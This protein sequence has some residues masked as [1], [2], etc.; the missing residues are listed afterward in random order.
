VSAS[1]GNVTD[2]LGLV[3]DTRYTASNVCLATP[4][5]DWCNMSLVTDS[6]GTTSLFTSLDG[7]V[8]YV[9]S[10]R[11]QF[12]NPIPGA[13]L[14]YGEYQGRSLFVVQGPASGDPYVPK[15]IWA[16]PDT[17]ARY[18]SGTPA[19]PAPALVDPFSVVLVG[20]TL[21][22]IYSTLVDFFEGFT[23]KEYLHSEFQRLVLDRHRSQCIPL[24]DFSAMVQALAYARDNDRA[25]FVGFLLSALPGSGSTAAR[26]GGELLEIIGGIAFSELTTRSPAAVNAAVLAEAQEAYAPYG[27]SVTSSTKIRIAPTPREHYPSELAWQESTLAN[28]V[29]NDPL[30]SGKLPL[31][32]SMRASGPLGN[33]D[34]AIVWADGF[35]QTI[36][37]SAQDEVHP[38]LSQSGTLVAFARDGDIWVVGVD[39]QN[40]S[41]LTRTA[42]IESLPKWSPDGSTLAFMKDHG[43]YNEIWTVRADGSLNQPL[44]SPPTGSLVRGI[45]WLDWSPDGSAVV[46]VGAYSG[47]WQVWVVA[48][49]RSYQRKLTNA[50]NVV[51]A[52]W[53]PD[54]RNILYTSD[55]SIWVT[56]VDGSSATR[57]SPAGHQAN[58]PRWSPDGSRILFSRTTSADGM[59]QAWVMQADGSGARLIIPESVVRNGQTITTYAKYARWLPDGRWISVRGSPG[60]VGTSPCNGVGGEALLLVDPDNVNPAYWIPLRCDVPHYDFFYEWVQPN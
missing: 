56:E 24:S 32:A 21:I 22:G 19:S 50:L 49:D 39:G 26:V 45:K 28:V 52:F 8:R 55:Q 2:S 27:I 44:T 18:Y 58:S 41:N 4:L 51:D 11:D 15:V 23:A 38:R 5:D 3:V 9:V 48:A 31:T 20:F 40:E 10:V 33:S 34:V 43:G 13:V 47:T 60:M 29:F 14:T 35:S 1:V 42:A 7:G 30:C 17:I 53:S 46:F 6:V 57:L 59:R 36:T 12:E 54:G 37:S 25:A 16:D